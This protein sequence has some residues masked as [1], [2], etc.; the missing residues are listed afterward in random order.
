MIVAI[1]IFVVLSACGSGA[2]ETSPL[3]S[4]SIPAN[5]LIHLDEPLDDPEHYC[6][7]VVGIDHGA[8]VNSPLHAHSCKSVRNLDQPFTVDKPETGQ[9]Y[10][11]TYDR[12]LQANSPNRGAALYIRPCSDS[13]LQRFD[14]LKDGS[15][16]LAKPIGTNPLCVVVAS[17]AGQLLGNQRDLRRDLLI[18]VCDRPEPNLTKWSY[19]LN[20][21]SQE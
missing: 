17:G 4:S 18:E 5:V 9:L 2:S 11:E 8:L 10:M 16:R 7:D 13:I 21:P 3:D 1:M 12:C 14:L 19:S 20:A 6:I 15:I